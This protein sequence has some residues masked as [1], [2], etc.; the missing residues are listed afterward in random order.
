MNRQEILDRAIVSELT[1]L[2]GWTGLMPRLR[3]DLIEILGVAVII[4]SIAAL[5][6]LWNL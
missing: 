4:L 3:P 5:M 1:T 6:V 2:S